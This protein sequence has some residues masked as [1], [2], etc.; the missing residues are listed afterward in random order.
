MKDIEL[1]NLKLNIYEFVDFY[2][3]LKAYFQQ[4]KEKDKRFSLRH[5][6]RRLGSKSPSFSKAILDKKQP[7]SEELFNE[8]T[9]MMAVTGEQFDYF[10]SLFRLEQYSEGSALHQRYYQRFKELRLK[11]PVSLLEAQHDCITSWFTLLMREVASLNGAQYNPLWFKKC[12]SPL[13][14]KN[15]SEIVGA[16]ELLK[17]AELIKETATGFEISDPLKEMKAT[18]PRLKL[19]HKELIELSLKF[20]KDSSQ[21]REFGAFAIA[22][23]P[24]KFAEMKKRLREFLNSQFLELEVQP[25]E[26][27]SV[28]SFSFQLFKLAD[29]HE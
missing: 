3:L 29:T 8:L 25:N 2:A 20:L 28:V 23:T 17:Q 4:C 24:E 7:I 27:K 19:L 15:V 10:E 13:L 6:S 5:F 16:I 18:D 21:N 9:E 14:G 12:L 22:T 11:K 26:G 1:S